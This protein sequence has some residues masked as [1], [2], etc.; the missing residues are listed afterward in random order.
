[1][2]SQFFFA[3]FR[4]IQR[5]KQSERWQLPYCDAAFTSQANADAEQRLSPNAKGVQMLASL[6]QT[7][8]SYYILLVQNL[9]FQNSSFIP[10]F[11]FLERDSV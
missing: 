4:L 11:F 9:S 6:Q 2:G 10:E 3:P 5:Q 7:L 8:D 1:M